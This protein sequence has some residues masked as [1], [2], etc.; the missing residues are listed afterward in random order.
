MGLLGDSVAGPTALLQNA[1]ERAREQTLTAH[2]ARR[3]P[4][5][6]LSA[7][8]LLLPDLEGLYE[9]L[10]EDAPANLLV[11]LNFR[12]FAASFEVPEEALS[13]DALL[14]E[15]A[16]DLADARR[17]AGKGDA[18]GRRLYESAARASAFFLVSQTL[19]A[20]LLAPSRKDLVERGLARLLPAA[21]DEDLT[22]SVLRLKVA[23]F[24]EDRDWNA[25]SPAF[26][27]LRRLLSRRTTG[28][29]AVALVP[30]NPA[31]TAAVSP[32]RLARNRAL[33]KRVV[34]DGPA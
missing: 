31:E 26:R 8:G 6:P 25:A 19:R 13:R 3:L 7:D 30:Q 9:R 5:L 32:E 15:R 11:L 28:F 34:E 20:R 16:A 17:R 29:T 22:A 27:S 18:M 24:S 10:G 1:V 21:D 23:P 4:V 12:M 2:L 14:P 33:V